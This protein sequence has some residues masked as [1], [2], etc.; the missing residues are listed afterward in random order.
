MARNL[1]MVFFIG[2]VATGFAY[3]QMEQ[4]FTPGN[5]VLVDAADDM[6][7]EV[8]LP[9][10]PDATEAQVVQ[11]IRWELGDTSRRRPLGVTFDPNGTCYIG[12]TSVPTSATEAVEFPSGRGEILRISS[13]GALDFFILDPE[14]TKGTWLSSFAPNELFL[15]SNGPKPPFPSHMF[16]Y[17]FSGGEISQITPFDVTETPQGN[18]D[19]GSGKA[20]I[21][22]DGRILIPSET[23]SWINI[24]NES[25]GAAI[26]QIPTEKAYRSLAYLKDSNEMLA[27]P[28]SNSSVDRI[29]IGGNILGS[30]DF[31]LDGLGGVWNFTLIDDGSERF[32]A[33]N[34]NGPAGSNSQIFIYDSSEL[35]DL[36]FPQILQIVGLE[37]FGDADGFANQL[38]DHAIVPEPSNVNIW[39]LY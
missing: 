34:H 5:L 23:D 9:G 26:D 29:D 36:P 10:S 25:G 35:E 1:W 17:S 15:M 4:P 22:P 2:L 11:V 38:F 19:G 14:V 27:I 13:N 24:Y 6:L 31:T 12:L 20:L 37:N 33:T 28:T 16:R 3:A 32:I 21:L 39:S 7:I 30:F 8:A 18:G